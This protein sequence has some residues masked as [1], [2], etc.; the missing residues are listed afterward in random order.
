[1]DVCMSGADTHRSFHCE[2]GG[3]CDALLD[4]VVVSGCRKCLLSGCV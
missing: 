1:M 2:G 3:R 4:A